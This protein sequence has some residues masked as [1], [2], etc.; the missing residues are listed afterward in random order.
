MHPVAAEWLANNGYWFEHERSFPDGKRPDFIAWKANWV[1]NKF[2]IVECKS[3]QHS[4]PQGVEQLHKY[5]KKLKAHDTE[6]ILIV[7]SPPSRV[8]PNNIALCTQENVR[9]V[10]IESD[11]SKVSITLDLPRNLYT[12]VATLAIINEMSIQNYLRNFLLECP[13][14]Q[15]LAVRT[16]VKLP[17]QW[18]GKREAK[19]E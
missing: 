11:L 1:E 5:A 10:C 2:A 14:V 18:G 8:A 13:E 7:L 4:I 16:Q 12:V 6:L 9:L 15:Q 3:E 17:R 19:A